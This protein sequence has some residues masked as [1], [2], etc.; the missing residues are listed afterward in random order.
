MT[1]LWTVLIS[2]LPARY[3]AWSSFDGSDQLRRAALLSGMFQA[4]VFT[5]VLIGAFITEAQGI[6]EQASTVVLNSEK[7]PMMD[8][9]QVR[10]TTGTLGVLNFLAQPLHL[11]YVYLAVEGAVRAFS[12]FIFSHVL[13][14]LPL[15]LI[16]LVHDALEAP[17]RTKRAARLARDVIEAAPDASYDLEIRS[18]LPKTWTP[19][20]GIQYRGELYVLAGE[21]NASGSHSHVYRLRRNPQGSLMA[22]TCRYVPEADA[23]ESFRVIRAIHN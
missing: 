16:S 11:L 10:L 3:R 7:G 8:P 4:A 13:P 22:V 1:F 2:L 12:G 5:F 23:A 19:Y 14:T 6:W 17:A 18:H 20:I 9:V 21:E 15:W